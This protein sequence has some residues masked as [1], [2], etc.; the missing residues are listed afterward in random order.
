MGQKSHCKILLCF[1]LIG[2]F[3]VGLVSVRGQVDAASGGKQARVIKAS[4]VTKTFGCDPFCILNEEI[5]GD[6]TYTS[7][8]KSVASINA[9]GMVTCKKVGSTVITISVAADDTYKAA[10]KEVTVTVESSLAQAKITGAAQSTSGITVS[11]KK[12]SGADG[13]QVYRRKSGESSYTR[14]GEVEG[15]STLSYQDK[16]VKKNTIYYYKVRAVASDNK[17]TG[18]KS[19]KIKVKY[20]DAPT[21]SLKK[22]QTGTQVKWTTVK[23]ATGYRIYRKKSSEKEYTRLKKVAYSGQVTYRDTTAKNGT[24]YDY[25]VAAYYGDYEGPQSKAKSYVYLS[26]PKGLSW[27]KKSATKRKA[28]WKENTKA[29]GYQIQYA[30]N[31][32]FAGAKS[33]KIG[34]GST[35]SYTASKLKKNSTYYMRVRAYKVVDGKTYYSAWKAGSDVKKTKTATR[36]Q[37]KKKGKTLELRALTKQKMGNY[38]TVQGSCTDGK[39][40]YYIMYNRKVEKCK[41]AKVKMSNQKLVK[42]SKVLKLDHGNDMTYDSDKKMLVVAHGTGSGLNKFTYVNPSTLKVKKNIKIS[43]PN[44]LEGATQAQIKNISSYAGIAYNSSRKQYV[45]LLSKSHNFLILD[46]DMNP[47]RYAKT[48]INGSYVMQGIDATADYVILAMSANTSKQQNVLMIYDWDGNFISKVNVGKGYELESIYHKGSKFYA[49]FYTSYYVT[50]YKTVTKT[51]TEDGKK[52][53]KKE[54]TP[55]RELRRDNYLYKITNL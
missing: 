29:D 16:N 27:T 12:V 3:A 40:A 25:T 6:V 5:D 10:E 42:V 49:S 23:G 2:L 44:K 51:V 4:D 21:V 19:E 46:G 38:D 13:Y 52:T 33:K 36:T 53:T 26:A 47:V 28:S 54:K 41:I 45:A 55:Y 7:S 11:W 8:S 37:V 34:K 39:Y 50:K 48:E 31:R 20:L 15:K 43:L 24:K 14:I 30:S 1:L 17:N 35:T 32:L 9:D 22:E 18:D